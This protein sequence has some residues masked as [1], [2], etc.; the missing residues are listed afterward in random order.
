MFRKILAVANNV[1]QESKALAT[2]A[3]LMQEVTAA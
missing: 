1:Q 3:W 2:V